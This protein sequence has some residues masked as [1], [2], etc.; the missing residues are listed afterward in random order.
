MFKRIDHIEIVPQNYE[1]TITFYCE[2]LGFTIKERQQVERPPMREII[3][4]ELGGTVVELIAVDNPKPLSKQD[5]QVG[6]RALALEVMDMDEA[7]NYLSSK[8]VKPS[9]GPVSL[10]KSKRAEITDPNG[11]QIELR[12]W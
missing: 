5:W 2:V 4:L 11:L 9:W 6:Y 8:G 1:E 10:G 12:Q 7:I 3:Y